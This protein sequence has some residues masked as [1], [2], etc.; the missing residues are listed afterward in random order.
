MR[1]NG[2]MPRSVV[3]AVIVLSALVALMHAPTTAQDALTN[4]E[5]DAI[6]DL[7]EQ[8]TGIPCRAFYGASG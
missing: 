2:S 5:V 6:V 4:A 7:V 1:R 8:R 3:V